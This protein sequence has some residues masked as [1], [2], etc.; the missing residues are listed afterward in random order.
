MEPPK[1]LAV[2]GA[3]LKDG[4]LGS[5]KMRCRL[6]GM[7]LMGRLFLNVLQLS[8][9]T[10]TGLLVDFVSDFI[11]PCRDYIFASSVSNPRGLDITLEAGY[12]SDEQAVAH[13][14]QYDAR[15]DLPLT[16]E[17]GIPVLYSKWGAVGTFGAF[18][19]FSAF[20]VVFL[21]ASFRGEDVFATRQFM[22]PFIRLMKGRS[23]RVEH[24]STHDTEAA[25]KEAND[26]PRLEKGNSS[27]MF[28][29]GEAYFPAWKFISIGYW[30]LPMNAAFEIEERARFWH[31]KVDDMIAATV[32]TLSLGL[33]FIPFGGF[34]AKFMEATNETPLVVP[35]RPSSLKLKAKYALNVV[36]FFC[37]LLTSVGVTGGLIAAQFLIL[38]QTMMAVAEDVAQEFSDE[39]F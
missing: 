37:T 3:K 9:S 6:L 13:A 8:V 16:S 39:L 11:H 10:A 27:V 29:E 4:F 28:K 17:G 12:R 14:E 23:F 24:I 30:N 35:G 25:A 26:P 34:L 31:G 21:I 22:A 2:R 7:S 15:P 18:V 1:K 38:I 5:V 19:V 36:K 20:Y 32:K 33:L